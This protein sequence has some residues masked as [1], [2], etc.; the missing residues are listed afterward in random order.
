MNPET[1]QPTPEPVPQPQ[2]VE[3]PEYQ[4]QPQ[5]MTYGSSPDSQPTPNEQTQSF[6]AEPAPSVEP[7]PQPVA[8][9]VAPVV[10]QPEAQPQMQQQQTQPVVN[11]SKGLSIATFV[12]GLIGFLTGFIGIGI[13]LGIVAVIMGIIALVKHSGGKGFAIAGLIL[14]ALAIITG[15]IF[16]A[17]TMVAFNGIQDRAQT[18][19]NKSTASV[20]VKKAEAYHAENSTPDNDNYPTYQQLLTADGIAKLEEEY[21]ENL[22][23]GG[24]ETVSASKPIAYK[25]C[26]AGVSVYYWDGYDA[27]A[28]ELSGMSSAERC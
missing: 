15:G 25:G 3:Q 7:E 24:I 8:P 26:S 14:G 13:L 2:P 9:A 11:K 22:H 10:P 6:P 23:E 17:I 12:I 1:N 16:L 27:G 18:T 4:A 19:L 28:K 21:K 5:S 20:I